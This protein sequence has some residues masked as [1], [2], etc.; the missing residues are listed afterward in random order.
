MQER[1][2]G[3]KE[4]KVAGRRTDEAVVVGLASELAGESLGAHAGDRVG[5]GLLQ[6]G[7]VRAQFVELVRVHATVRV[8]QSVIISK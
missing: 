6:F 3:R 4:R 8:A 1:K 7:Q 5:K 2:E